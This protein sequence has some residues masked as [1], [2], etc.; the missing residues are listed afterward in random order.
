MRKDH[1]SL[2][3][4]VVVIV[5]TQPHSYTK[6][7]EKEISVSAFFDELSEFSHIV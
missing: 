5:D 3:N 4:I 7:D 6:R 2:E 1:L